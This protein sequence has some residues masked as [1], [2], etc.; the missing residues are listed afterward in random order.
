MTVFLVSLFAACNKDEDRMDNPQS[1]AIDKIVFPR[2]FSFSTLREINLEFVDGAD[3]TYRV[4]GIYKQERDFITGGSSVNGRFEKDLEISSHYEK[5]VVEK[6]TAAGRIV[7]EYSLQAGT[8]LIT[9]S[10]KAK[11]ASSSSD[12]LYAI[13]NDAEMFTIDL[14]DYSS[15]ALSTPMKGSIALAVD[16][17]VDRVFYH[18]HPNMY[19]YDIA[20]GVHSVFA[21]YNSPFNGNFPRM[22]YDHTT[23]YL[24]TANGTTLREINPA[25]GG[26]VST[27]SIKGIVNSTT[28]GD[29]ALPPDGNMYMSCFSGLY[30][31]DLLSNGTAQATRLS[32]ENF[33]FQL[34]SLGYDH[35]GMLYAATN[36]GNARL[37]KI[38]PVDGSWVHVA[39]FNQK[40][41]DLGSVPLDLNT[42][43]QAD[44]DGDGVVDVLDVAPCDPEIAHAEYTPSELGNGT[45]AFEDLWPAQGDFDFN[46]MVIRYHYTKYLNAQNQMVKLVGKF[47]IKAMGASYNNG[48]GIELDLSQGYIQSVTGSQ[49]TKGLVNL[50]GK[51]LEVGN[52]KP[53]IIVFDDALDQISNAAGWSFIN[54]LPN[55]PV[56]VGDTIT[57]TVD[58]VQPIAPNL[59]GDAPFNPFIF[60]DGTRGRELHLADGKPTQMISTNYFGA[61]D[62]NSIPS[63]ERYYKSKNN[64]PWALDIGYEFRHPLEKTPINQGYN[65]FV[66][67][68]SSGGTI[69]K[70]W[71]KDNTGYRN[72]SK[73][74]LD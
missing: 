56:V 43:P 68:A 64:L 49:I 24:Y 59:A 20:S 16:T 4:F 70:D 23:G 53:T 22:E 17:A 26:I 72:T 74:F 33:P 62:D 48:F 27:Y 71:Y 6:W 65:E 66:N 13:N 3:A 57:I 52:I 61:A 10:F 19:E 34:T 45:L 67:W 73:L 63:Q 5:L 37:I 44:C 55:S 32:A 50:N 41:H 7:R 9:G 36:E 42:V 58:F 18:K 54:T 39:T 12:V 31:L 25:T 15:Q 14:S 28:G 60:I 46:D 21:T 29:L 35:T 1:A 51:G 30:K 2:N 47:Q 38:D 40:I 69:S 11:T 8:N